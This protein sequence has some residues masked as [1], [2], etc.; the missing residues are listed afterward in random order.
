MPE[1]SAKYP[2]ILFFTPEGKGRL[3]N[4]SD[5]APGLSPFGLNPNQLRFR[6]DYCPYR[7]AHEH[8]QVKPEITRDTCINMCNNH[9]TRG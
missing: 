1:P 2:S 7:E 5:N 8:H 6:A 4:G 3:E 9:R